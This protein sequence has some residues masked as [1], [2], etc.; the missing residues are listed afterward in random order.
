MNIDDKD[1]LVISKHE[2]HVIVVSVVEFDQ[3]MYWASNK[4]K[5]KDVFNTEFEKKFN[6]SLTIL[7]YI[8]DSLV[9]VF[10]NINE[11]K[12][13]KAFLLFSKYSPGKKQ[14]I[15]TALTECSKNFED[16][17][18][19]I[20]GGITQEELDKVLED[21]KCIFPEISE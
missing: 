7:N 14:I 9:E 12:A 8:N 19:S 2:L 1:R 6:F 4:V 15:L 18:I 3:E 17:E 21:F 11:L 13:E 10:S 5:D 20:R 16:Y